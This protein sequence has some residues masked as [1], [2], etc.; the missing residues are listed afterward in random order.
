MILVRQLSG[1]VLC[2]LNIPN[3]APYE[4]FRKEIHLKISSPNVFSSVMFLILD[5]V[6]TSCIKV[7]NSL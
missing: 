5:G 6:A 3:T 4:Q 7:D 2:T 1:S